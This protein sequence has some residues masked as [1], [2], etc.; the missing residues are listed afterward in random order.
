MSATR[1]RVCGGRPRFYKVG[2]GP[3]H[4]E[5]GSHS[6]AGLGESKPGRI[7]GRGEI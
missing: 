2:D 6:L 5:R 7:Q 4:F 3:P 1:E